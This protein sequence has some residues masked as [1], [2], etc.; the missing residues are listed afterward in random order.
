MPSATWVSFPHIAC[1]SICEYKLYNKQVQFNFSKYHLKLF[2]LFM[3]ATNSQESHGVDKRI[4]E[5]GCTSNH[6]LNPLVLLATICCF[7][8]LLFPLPLF[9]CWKYRRKCCSHH[10]CL[11]WHRR[12]QY[13]LFITM[14]AKIDFLFWLNWLHTHHR[15]QELDYCTKID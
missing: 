15:G 11:L 7:Q 6:F 3:L 14:H 13:L 2:Y 4:L 1:I 5:L 10:R 12:G 8:V 9:L